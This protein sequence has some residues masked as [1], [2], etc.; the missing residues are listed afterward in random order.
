MS[1]VNQIDKLYID[2]QHMSYKLD[3]GPG[4]RARIG[5]IVLAT[6]L[7]LEHEFRQMLNI[8]GV[9]FY[10]SR[11]PNST[12]VTKEDLKTM[13]AS[14]TQAAD[15]ILP[16][17]ELD[18]IAY[19]CTSASMFIGFERIHAEIRKARPDVACTTPMEAVFAALKVLNAKRICFI[20]PYSEDINRSMR[21]FLQEHGFEVPVMGS[22][23]LMDDN[24]IARISPQSIRDAILE[25]GSSAETDA[26]FL[27]CTNLRLANDVETLERELG[28]PVTASNHA[29][30]WHCLRLAGI[31]DAVAGYGRLFH[32]RLNPN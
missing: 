6:D 7:S 12:S 18:V 1:V 22:W 32:L 24:T 9:A 23:N 28:K 13:A 11:I 20:A 27:S 10:E 14:M 4:Y 30:A 21:A 25:L 5:V 2:R 3:D 8:P 31:G 26:V 17:V 29:L 19:G 16:G 15:L